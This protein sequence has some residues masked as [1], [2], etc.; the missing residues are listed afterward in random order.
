MLKTLI[1]AAVALA[2]AVPAF[3]GQ[4]ERGTREEAIAMVER[5]VALYEA[6]GVDA[7]IAA[8][9]DSG[10]AGF[11]DRDLYPVLLDFEHNML[12]HGAK[13]ALVGKN[14]ANFTD[15]DGVKINQEAQKVA[16][17]E[18]AGW[19]SYKWQNPTTNQIEQKATYVTGIGGDMWVGVG[20]YEN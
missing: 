12:A 7:L 19:I 17:T 4:A 6:E 15:I 18:G 1:G 20:V 13:A 2:L 8:I 5:A 9:M 16:T 14:L 11:H 10:N 3:A